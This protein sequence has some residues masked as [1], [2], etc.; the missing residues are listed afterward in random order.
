MH[1][2]YYLLFNLL[3]WLLLFK[4]ICVFIEKAKFLK[5]YF[6]EKSYSLF[7]FATFLISFSFFIT[8]LKLNFSYKMK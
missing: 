6:N 8:T 2:F 3:L 1:N 5:F 7:L 4:D